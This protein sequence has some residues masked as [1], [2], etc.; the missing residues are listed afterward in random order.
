MS[1]GEI[2]PSPV[3]VPEN[4]EDDDDDY[5]SDDEPNFEDLTMGG[6]GYDSDPEIMLRNNARNSP[7]DFTNSVTFLTVS[8]PDSS[9]KRTSSSTPDASPKRS[10]KQQKMLSRSMNFARN[11]MSRAIYSS[12]DVN[13]GSNSDMNIENSGGKDENTNYVNLRASAQV[14]GNVEA[15]IA[16]A[17]KRRELINAVA[18]QSKENRRARDRQRQ[19]QEEKEQQEEEEEEKE[20]EEREEKE[21]SKYDENVGAIR[22]LVER[23]ANAISELRQKQDRILFEREINKR[24]AAREER[25]EVIEEPVMLNAGRWNIGKERDGEPGTVG[26]GGIPRRTK[27]L[28]FNRNVGNSNEDETNRIARIM[29]FG[30]DDDSV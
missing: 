29:G 8:T 5:S 24:V 14:G 25:E 23:N 28:I 3:T 7:N 16:A 11:Y 18:T 13:N 22:E 15:A 10:A 17:K 21:E 9:P 30:S 6:G 27:P 1:G 26:G 4:E 2:R 12:D 20:E 19:L